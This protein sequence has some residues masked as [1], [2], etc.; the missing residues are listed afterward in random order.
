MYGARQGANCTDRWYVIHGGQVGVVWYK[1]I[2]SDVIPV[3]PERAVTTKRG[4]DIAKVEWVIG[5]EQ[6][7]DLALIH[8][9]DQI[10][11]F[12]ALPPEEKRQYNFKRKPSDPPILQSIWEA[13]RQY[14][15]LKDTDPLPALKWFE[16]MTDL[17]VKAQKLRQ[18]AM[19]RMFMW[20][21][22]AED[23]EE[24]KQ[25]SDDD[26]LKLAEDAK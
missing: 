20:K 21:K 2:M 9:I 14:E 12:C 1:P 7:K 18:E 24:T 23:R 11:F 15:A 16:K 13:H 8:R 17:L 3:E 26:L 19:D 10:Q 22:V 5:R 4:L 25:L 6:E